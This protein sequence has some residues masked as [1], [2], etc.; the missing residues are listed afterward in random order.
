M[1]ALIS[2]FYSLM[3]PCLCLRS[4]D[5]CS[6]LYNRKVAGW[7]SVGFTGI[8]HG[9]NSLGHTKY[10]GLTQALTVLSTGNIF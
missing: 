8:F 6:L 5:I 7:I 10:M 2:K 1:D 3:C 9:R 4:K